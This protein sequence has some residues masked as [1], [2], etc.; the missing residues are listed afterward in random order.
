MGWKGG[1]GEGKG[2]EGRCRGREGSALLLDVYWKLLNENS[3]GKI[4]LKSVFYFRYWNTVSTKIEC[5]CSKDINSVQ[6]L[7]P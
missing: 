2:W 3:E 6:D 7:T 1:V 4:I 5:C